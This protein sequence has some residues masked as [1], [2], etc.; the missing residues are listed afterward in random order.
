[1]LLQSFHF[2]TFFEPSLWKMQR[3]KRPFGVLY[4]FSRSIKEGLRE[5]I[6]KERKKHKAFFGKLHGNK[7]K[8]AYSE[9]YPGLFFPLQRH[10][11]SWKYWLAPWALVLWS[12]GNCPCVSQ[13]QTNCVLCGVGSNPPKHWWS[14]DECEC[15]GRCENALRKI[16]LAQSGEAYAIVGELGLKVNTF[17]S[18]PPK[19]NCAYLL[20]T[21]I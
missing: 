7:F 20:M 18:P 6:Q 16:P 3:W 9:D 5:A 19:Y 14:T 1:M 8:K 21:C 10:V 4:S 17:W 12:D 13:V 15:H 2:G 11:S